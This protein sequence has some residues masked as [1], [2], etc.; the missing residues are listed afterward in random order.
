RVLA[1]PTAASSLAQALIKKPTTRA[2]DLARARAGFPSGTQIRWDESSGT[3]TFISGK[4]W[5]PT[6]LAKGPAAELSA[7]PARVDALGKA[8]VT[9]AQMYQGIPVWGRELTAHFDPDGG[10]YAL[11]ARS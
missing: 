10:L 3:P 2:L 7:G 8:H 11:N 9:Y 6:G 1:K 5:R 4:P